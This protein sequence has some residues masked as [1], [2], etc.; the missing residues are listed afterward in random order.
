MLEM[1]PVL[2]ASG[3]ERS[4]K[5]DFEDQDCESPQSTS[6]TVQKSRKFYRLCSRDEKERAAAL[7]AL[8]K[9]VLSCLGQPG[10]SANVGIDEDTLLQLLQVAKTCPFPDIRERASELLKTAQVIYIT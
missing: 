9:S 3:W 8:T 6:E 10:D 4:R 7:E 1:T 5:H 2:S